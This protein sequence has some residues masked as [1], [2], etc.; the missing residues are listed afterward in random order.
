MQ[1][2]IRDL[3]VFGAW[4]DNDYQEFALLT[5]SMIKANDYES[6]NMWDHITI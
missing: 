5:E 2:M 4:Q 1:E 6:D 3:N